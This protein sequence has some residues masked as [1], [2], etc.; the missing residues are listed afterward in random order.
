MARFLKRAPMELIR[1][2]L[3]VRE[4][5]PTDLEAKV[6]LVAEARALRFWEQFDER[7]IRWS[8]NF[9]RVADPVAFVGGLIQGFTIANVPTGSLWLVERVR[10]HAPNILNVHIDTA[11]GLGSNNLQ[12]SARYLDR[13]EGPTD[14]PVPLACF[15]S[16]SGLAPTGN[17]V[18]AVDPGEEHYLGYVGISTAQNVSGNEPNTIALATRAVNLPFDATVSGYVIMG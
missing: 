6:Q 12:V 15:T 9:A 11:P 7:V 10:N 17:L 3:D 2:L 16:S 4:Q 13:R 1:R 8:L 5:L 14:A 18:A